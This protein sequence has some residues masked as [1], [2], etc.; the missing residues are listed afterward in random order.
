V[1]VQ[2]VTKTGSTVSKSWPAVCTEN[3]VVTSTA[4]QHV[5]SST[6]QV[7]VVVARDNKNTRLG[8]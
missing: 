1:I 6:E 8:K 7:Q 4:G 3:F 2:V 5:R